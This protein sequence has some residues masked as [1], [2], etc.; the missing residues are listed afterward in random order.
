LDIVSIEDLVKAGV[1]FGHRTKRWNPKMRK[2]IFGKRNGVHII[3]LRQTMETIK[4]AYEA[5]VQVAEQG[6]GILFVGTKKQA[7]DIVKEEAQRGGIFYITERW[8]G[9]LLTNF[10]IVNTRIHR[11]REF[12][13]MKEDG[14]WA[15]MA[16]K[17]QSRCEREYTKLRK[18]FEGIKDMDRLPGAVFLVDIKKDVTAMREAKRKEIPIIAIIDTNVDPTDVSFPIP[19]NDD[20]IRSISLITKI[21]TDAVVEGRKGFETEEEEKESYG[22]GKS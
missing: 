15:L 18:Y 8:L 20:S 17:E 19:A 4:R 5:M 22:T 10:D 7:K 12:E 21:M 14:R 2:Y 6:K 13:Q 16:K 11:L 3:D 1:H 9:G